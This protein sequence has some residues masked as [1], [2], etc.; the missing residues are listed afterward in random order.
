MKFLLIIFLLFV[1]CVSVKLKTFYVL[2]SSND[3]NIIN[4]CIEKQLGK[5]T[6]FSVDKFDSGIYEVKVKE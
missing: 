3:V 6:I 1:S 5:K 4:E 2:C